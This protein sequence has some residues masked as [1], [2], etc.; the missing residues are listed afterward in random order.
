MTITAS[1]AIQC[2][3]ADGQKG[4]YL[5]SG[6]HPHTGILL[7]P[8]LDNVAE[9]HRWA[10]AHGWTPV[11]G[12]FAGSYERTTPLNEP[13][14]NPGEP[15]D[16]QCRALCIAAGWRWYDDSDVLEGWTGERWGIAHAPTVDGRERHNDSVYATWRECWREALGAPAW[17]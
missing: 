4:T 2:T 16:G 3:A 1:L 5:F 11:P 17:K 13:L 14:P 15:N 9:L 10:S 7:S 8:V 12:T 6:D